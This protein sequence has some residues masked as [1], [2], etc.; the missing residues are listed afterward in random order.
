[1]PRN[2]KYMLTGS[3]HDAQLRTHKVMCDDVRYRLFYDVNVAVEMDWNVIT[4]TEMFAEI[5]VLEAKR[6]IL[7]AN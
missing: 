1:M 5:I 2:L 4:L 6:S 7:G 3:A